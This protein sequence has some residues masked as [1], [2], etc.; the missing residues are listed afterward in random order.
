MKKSARRN[1]QSEIKDYVKRVA[2]I[3]TVMLSR[4]ANN[5]C[6]GLPELGEV[7]EDTANQLLDVCDFIRQRVLLAKWLSEKGSPHIT[8]QTSGPNFPLAAIPNS[9]REKAKGYRR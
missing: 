6:M 4:L 7:I 5:Q 2:V 3:H 8:D 1:T 9:G